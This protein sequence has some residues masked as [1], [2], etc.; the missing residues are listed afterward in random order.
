MKLSRDDKTMLAKQY[1]KVWGDDE[2]MVE[3]CVKSASGYIRFGREL[4]VMDKPHIKTE[5]CFGEHGY[6]YDE[7]AEECDRARSDVERFKREN[8]AWNCKAQRHL[9]EMEDGRR[10]PYIFLKHYYSQPDDCPLCYVQWCSEF[11]SRD[12]YDLKSKP[13]RKMTDEEQSRFKEFCE[14]EVAKFEKRLDTYLKR[15]GLS[16]C[17]FWTYWADR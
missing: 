13:N 4:L 14:D 1:G 11:D 8:I 3:H 12:A 6:D 10:E 15:Y 9:D 7:V 16:K 2:K 5:F 17:H